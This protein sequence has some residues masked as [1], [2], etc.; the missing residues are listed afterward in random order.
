ML[1]LAE[2]SWTLH[3]SV[4][5]L[6]DLVVAEELLHMRFARSSRAVLALHIGVAAVRR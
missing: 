2:T 6:I 3:G 4:P 5:H 1:G